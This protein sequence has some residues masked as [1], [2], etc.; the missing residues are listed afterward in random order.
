MKLKKINFIE[1]W[2]IF[3]LGGLFL[4]CSTTSIERFGKNVDLQIII[5]DEK[6]QP[7]EDFKI[8]YSKDLKGSKSKESFTNDKGFCSFED[9][10][11]GKYFIWGTKH[12]YT[13]IEGIEIITDKSTDIF[14]C[15]TMSKHQVFD[16]TKKLYKRKRFSEGLELLS[17]LEAD[18]N[19]ILENGILFFEYYGLVNGDY[20]SSKDIQKRMNYIKKRTNN[21]F[22]ELI[23]R[24]D[25]GDK[26]EK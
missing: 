5:L 17:K 3:L 7:V 21:E 1:L 2:M 13:K 14:F 26:N 6:N 10:S 22:S 8:Q 11:K 4:S 18:K 9:L 12:G 19:S 24:L 20:D 23:E 25:G 16:N 15:Q